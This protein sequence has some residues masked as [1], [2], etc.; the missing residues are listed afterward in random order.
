MLRKAA[1]DE[2]KDWD[3]LVPYLLF[4]YREVPQDSTGFSPFELLY[5]RCVRGPLDIL[6]E[7][8]VASERADESVVSHI[9]DMREKLSKMQAIVQDNLKGSQ[10]WQKRWYDKSARHREFQQGDQVL[11]L[12]PT[13]TNKLLAQWQGP[14]KVKDRVG[15]VNYLVEMHDRRKKHQIFH[16]NMLKKWHTPAMDAYLAMEDSPDVD[17][18]EDMPVWNENDTLT[19]DKPTMGSQLNMKQRQELEKLLYEYREVMKN[20]PGKTTIAEHAIDTGPA[21]PVR[22]P[23]YRLP[24]VYKDAVYKEIQDML[25][26]GMIEPSTSCWASPIVPVRKKDGSIR[27]CVDYRRLNSVSKHD[28]YPMPRI[29]DIIDRIGEAKYI[30]A[31][32]LTRGYWQVPM[33]AADHHKTAFTTPMGLFQFT[34]MPF[35]LSGAPAT[36][37]RMMDQILSGLQFSAA[38]LDDLVVFSDTWEEHL[39]HLRNILERLKSA[40]LTAKLKKC[41]FGMAECHYLG[42]IVGSGVVRPEHDKIRAVRTFQVPRTKKEVRTFL[43]ITGYYRKFIHGYATTAAP[44]TDLTRKSSSNLITWT[45]ECQV[46]F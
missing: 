40:G 42:H 31:L 13:S 43:G 39:K 45:E 35:G 2:G 38:Y 44:L 28:A 11:V 22:L 12:L 15:N 6:K 25:Q 33:S 1:V 4:A 30:S 17:N 18:E 20:K 32:D 46:A 41:Q 5:G 24:H 26:A 37:Q 9:L 27:L 7:S 23:P 21:T 8:W 36:F 10:Q 19:E 14:Y 16:V 3:R 34:V 29:D